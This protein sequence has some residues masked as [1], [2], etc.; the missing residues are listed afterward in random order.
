MQSEDSGISQKEDTQ[1]LLEVHGGTAEEY[2]LLRSRL[3]NDELGEYLSFGIRI[4]WSGETAELIDLA[5]DEEAVRK[6]VLLCAQENASPG[7]LTELAEDFLGG[8]YGSV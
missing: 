7:Q 2:Q 6:F 5:P 1:I 3:W 4:R 8:L